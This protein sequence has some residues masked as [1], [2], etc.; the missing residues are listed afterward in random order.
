MTNIWIGVGRLARDPELRYGESTKAVAAMRIAVARA[1][2]GDDADF[3][4]VACF[5]QLAEACA[6]HLTKGR[7]V[8]VEGSLRQHTWTDAATSERRSRVEVVANRV[9][10][11]DGP[12]RSE[13][14]P[15]AA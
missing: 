6:T 8:L 9:Q 7:Q 11:L 14:S 2:G 4:D 1:G 12:R 15:A 13:D 3:F 10:F 5:G